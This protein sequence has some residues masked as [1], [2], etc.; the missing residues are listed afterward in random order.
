MSMLCTPASSPVS[1]GRIGVLQ[2]LNKRDGTNYFSRDDE[3]MTATCARILSLVLE[4]A[5]QIRPDILNHVRYNR[6]FFLLFLL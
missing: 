6:I 2:I 5:L 4:R 3:I 1:G